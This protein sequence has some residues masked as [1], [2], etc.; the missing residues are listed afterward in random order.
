[1]RTLLNIRYRSGMTVRSCAKNPI[2]DL[3]P[4]GVGVKNAKSTFF[5][6]EKHDLK[7]KTKKNESF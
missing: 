2:T 6:N 1:M 7:I 4:T 3:S 5:Q